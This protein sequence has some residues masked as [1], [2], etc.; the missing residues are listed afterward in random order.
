MKDVDGTLHHGPRTVAAANQLSI[1]AAPTRMVDALRRPVG[2]VAR[3]AIPYGV[4]VAAGAICNA[5]PGQS[6]LEFPIWAAG[7]AGFVRSIYFAGHTVRQE[8]TQDASLT[9]RLAGLLPFQRS[10]ATAAARMLKAEW[11]RSEIRTMGII[12]NHGSLGHE[13]RITSV[14]LPNGANVTFCHRRGRRPIIILNST[15][16][17]LYYSIDPRHS[18]GRAASSVVLD[19]IRDIQT[20]RLSVLLGVEAGHARTTLSHMLAEALSLEHR[21]TEVDETIG[22]QYS[23]HTIK[24]VVEEREIPSVE[25]TVTAIRHKYHRKYLEVLVEAPG[26]GVMTLPPEPFGAIM[27]RRHSQDLH[28]AFGVKS[29]DIVTLPVFLGNARATRIAELARQVLLE[30]PNLVD[31]SGQ[32]L[33]RLV[34]EHMPRLLTKHR[35]STRTARSSDIAEIDDALDRG[36]SIIA[37]ELDAALD[38]IANR[39]LDD[40]RTELRFLESRHPEP[41]ERLA[42]I[43]AK[44]A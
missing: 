31:G 13:N 36:L 35:N 10:V 8:L 9:N 32:P 26:I 12:G 43:T 39:D 21:E 33:R 5:I 40:L 17:H 1:P 27:N 23:I 38:Q 16:Q 34:D 20:K 44:V 25:M 30:D 6:I 15:D 7:V 42:P 3:V 4:A 2:R 14:T 24:Y 19:A 28:Q 37:R 29:P 18:L 41:D 22:D 11:D